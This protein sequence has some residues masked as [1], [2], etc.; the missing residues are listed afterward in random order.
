MMQPTNR[1]RWVRWSLCAIGFAYVVAA[2]ALFLSAQNRCYCQEEDPD[3]GLSMDNETYEEHLIAD[4]KDE[5]DDF[6]LG[7]DAEKDTYKASTLVLVFE[8]YDGAKM[9]NFKTTGW[10]AIT[11]LEDDHV[12]DGGGTKRKHAHAKDD[13]DAAALANA[14]K[15]WN[16]RFDTDNKTTTLKKDSATNKTN[17][18]AHALG[19]YTKKG[20]YK[21]W[22]NAITNGE[23]TPCFEADTKAVDTTKNPCKVND[24]IYY[25]KAH[26][27]GIIAVDC[28]GKPTKL[29]WQWKGSGVYSYDVPKAA[30]DVLHTPFYVA[31]MDKGPNGDKTDPANNVRRP[32]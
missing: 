15:Y 23:A 31:G 29:E 16:I 27:T 17:C 19:N 21:F 11:K 1:F 32:K 14:D 8:G 28:G 18:Y 2:C 22:I 13:Y 7:S 3:I 24:V 9:K 20:T 6:V 5:G 12:K 30:K 26:A 25:V 10:F 4:P